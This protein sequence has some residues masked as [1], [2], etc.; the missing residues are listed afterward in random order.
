MQTPSKF[1][2]QVTTPR[3]QR[4]PAG[5]CPEA[6]T[7]AQAHVETA[8]RHNDSYRQGGGGGCGWMDGQQERTKKGKEE[9]TALFYHI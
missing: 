3:A 6:V 2:R 4:R 5:P 9:E 8:N 7:L 1:D